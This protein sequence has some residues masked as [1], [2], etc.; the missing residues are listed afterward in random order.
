MTE[1]YCQ[2]KPTIAVV[3][4]NRNDAP[5]LAT[6]L[7]SVIGQQ[8]QADEVIVVDDQSTDN[9]L[10]VIREKVAM[11]PN[12]QLV[13]NPKQLGTMGALNVGLRHCHCDYVLFLSSNDYLVDGIFTRAKDCIAANGYP[14]IWSAMVWEVDAD[15]LAPRLYPSPAI[16]LQG[17]LLSADQV[18]RWVHLYGHWFTGITLVYERKTLIKCGGFDPR[19]KGLSDMFSALMVASL[20]GAYFVPEP[21][22]VMRRHPGGLMWQTSKDLDRLDRIIQIMARKGGALSPKL[23]TPDFAE[24]MERRIRFTAFRAFDDVA[25]RTHLHH[26]TGRR[27]ALLR[28]VC[29]ML[30]QLRGIQLLAAFLIL[31]PMH[32]VLGMF[33]QRMLMTK[34]ILASR[35]RWKKP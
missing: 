33:W 10:E 16:S 28:R 25:W 21:L 14:G 35:Y 32:D 13:V 34:I 26:W 5:T 3:I 12:A 4:P 22:G 2:V 8:I 29:S 27:Y 7:D 17:K 9:S 1:G 19:L 24:L 23:Y 15:G 30:P 31:R 6:C 11:L 18:I 20:R